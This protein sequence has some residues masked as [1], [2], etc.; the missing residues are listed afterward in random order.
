V[1]W[2]ARLFGPR[3]PAAP[4]AA[5]VAGAPG[6]S[7]GP[8]PAEPEAAS[9]AWL[10]WLLDGAPPTGAPL[11]VD[12][13][14]ALAVLDKVLAAGALPP[15]LLPRAA[16]LIPQLLAMLRQTQLPVAALAQRVSRD[17][18][19][20]AEVLRRA[21][22]PFY[23]AQG[24]VTDLQQAIVLI[25]EQGLQAVIARVLLK[26]VFEASPG[27]LGARSAT[28]LWDYAEAMAEQTSQQAAA[29]GLP[30][31]DGYLAGL[32]QASGWTVALR[33]LDRNG[34]LPAL[35]VSAR[36]EAALVGRVHRLFG[37]AAQGWP[38]TPGF[39]ACAADAAVQPMATSRQP[40]VNAMRKAQAS[41]LRA[42]AG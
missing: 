4:A 35:P 25:G 2:L 16:A 38:I 27:V 37:L 32:L 9:P 20:A 13:E 29:A 41:A 30:A 14:R 18:V 26:P 34:I 24:E 19:L 28:R 17:M 33:V 39:A 10:S 5:G 23:R 12:E 40:L 8:P 1:R 22:S 21:S 11:A 15:E 7:A 42:L 6:R 31:F 3:R 36:F